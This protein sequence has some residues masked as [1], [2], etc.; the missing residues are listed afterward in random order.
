M[1]LL[2][3]KGVDSNRGE[4]GAVAQRLQRDRGWAQ[5]ADGV[6]AVRVLSSPATAQEQARRDFCRDPHGYRVPGV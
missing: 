1:C 3:R 2:N 5:H 6:P 4:D